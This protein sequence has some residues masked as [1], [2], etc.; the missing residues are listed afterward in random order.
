MNTNLLFRMNQPKN[1]VREI[2]YQ[3]PVYLFESD[4]TLF[5]DPAMGG[6]D[7]LRSVINRL[8]EFGHSVEN[9]ASRIYG[10]EDNIIFVNR[11]KMRNIEN[12]IQM[13]YNEVLEWES[14][15]RF[16]VII[17]N[18][19]YQSNNGAGT[20]AGSSKPLWFEFVKLSL[21]K[22][23]DGGYLSF[24]TPQNM[25]NGSSSFTKNFIGNKA[26]NNT[27]EGIENIDYQFNND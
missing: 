13:S 7:Y 26:I 2:V 11:A 25:F 1:L 6:G 21:N 9:I 18:P 14:D 15:M 22:L 20:L 10:I 19:P 17:G 23:K 3:L 24:I 12:F 16:D 4:S 5:L 8:I 27:Y